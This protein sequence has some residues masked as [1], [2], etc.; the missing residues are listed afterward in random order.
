[1]C[2][3]GQMLAEQVQPKT[4]RSPSR[5]IRCADLK[6]FRGSDTPRDAVGSHAKVN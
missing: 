2:E 5:A 4:L 6:R 1:M 3:A